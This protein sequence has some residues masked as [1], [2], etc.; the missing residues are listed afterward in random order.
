MKFCPYSALCSHSFLV[1]RYQAVQ[2][3]LFFSRYCSPHLLLMNLS[4]GSSTPCSVDMFWSAFRIQGVNIHKTPTSCPSKGI[5]YTRVNV[6]KGYLRKPQLQIGSAKIFSWRSSWLCATNVISLASRGQPNVSQ[7]WH[8]LSSCHL[9][10][11]GIF[12]ALLKSLQQRSH[13]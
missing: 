9:S 8:G 10:L 13:T 1:F 6:S 2:R 7:S 4:R 11:T 5:I 3:L 12:E